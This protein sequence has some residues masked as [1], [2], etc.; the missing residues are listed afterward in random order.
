MRKWPP[1]RLDAPDPARYDARQKE[2]HEA[3]ASGPRG[4]VRGP[5]AVWLHRPELAAAAQT[6]G[7]YCRYN[8]LLEPRHS[9][10]AIL[11][12][13]RIFCS[14]Y[15]WQAH[16][17]IALKAGVEADIVEAIRRN[18]R[19]DFADEKDAVVYDVARAV[20][21]ERNLDDALYARAVSVLG[22]PAL[23]D[24]IGLLSYY[25]LI[26]LTINVF[27]VPPMGNDPMPELD[28]A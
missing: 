16:K 17:S 13:G 12:T 24:L 7:R 23:V 9:E 22:E 28:D 21:E 4:G 5:L 18:L 10:L 27:R 26:S 15:E 11:V 8:T 6:L 3:I 14:E 25:T 2:I 19:P 20:H 1:Q